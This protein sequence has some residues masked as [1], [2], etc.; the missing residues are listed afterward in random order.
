[1]VRALTGLGLKEAKD[2]VVGAP[3][4]I[5]GNLPTGE[6]KALKKRLEAAGAEVTLK[7]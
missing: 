1:V 3:R 6:A 5:Q 2:L 4:P 7:P